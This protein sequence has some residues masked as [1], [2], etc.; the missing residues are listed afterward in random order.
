MMMIGYKLLVISV[1]I[2]Y[3]ELSIF[4]CFDR[5]KKEDNS[6]VEYGWLVRVAIVFSWTE[7]SS[8]VV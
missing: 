1:E 3:S 2:I 7:I 6:V 4:R 8:V 5:C